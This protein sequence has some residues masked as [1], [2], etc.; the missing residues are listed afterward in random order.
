MGNDDLQPLVDARSVGDDPPSSRTPRCRDRRSDHRVVRFFRNARFGAER[1]P[2]VGT[3]RPAPPLPPS[4]SNRPV[5][6]LGEHQGA[7][8]QFFRAQLKEQRRVEWLLGDCH[9][10]RV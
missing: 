5:P 8:A 2:P 4:C 9:V 1:M 7:R 3:D 10:P 6:G